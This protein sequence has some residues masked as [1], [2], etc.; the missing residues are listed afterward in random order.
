M[1]VFRRL[2][3]LLLTFI[4]VKLLLQLFFARVS[5][6]MF[7]FFL[8]CCFVLCFFSRALEKS[9]NELKNHCLQLKQRNDKWN[10]TKTTRRVSYLL[11]QQQ[12]SQLSVGK[13]YTTQA[14]TCTLS[15]RTRR[16]LQPI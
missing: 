4:T 10:N 14:S 1:E 8:V 5:A 16:N 15:P 3:G 6:F 9:T 2:G 7:I 11:K 13:I 12:Q